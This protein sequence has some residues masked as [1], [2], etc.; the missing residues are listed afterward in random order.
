[1]LAA[2]SVLGAGISLL[3]P[4]HDPGAEPFR[5]QPAEAVEEAV[6]ALP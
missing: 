3:R 4:R 5:P 1:V 2:T 6:A